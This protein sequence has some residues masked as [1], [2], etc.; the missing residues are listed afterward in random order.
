[1]YVEYSRDV[2][3]RCEHGLREVIPLNS[4]GFLTLLPI[5]LPIP[6]GLQKEESSPASPLELLP[7]LLLSFQT[8]FDHP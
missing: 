7:T 1:M 5:S 2:L 8:L 3:N 6:M 4:A